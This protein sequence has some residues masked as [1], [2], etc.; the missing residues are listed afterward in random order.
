L[1]SAGALTGS[2]ASSGNFSIPVRVSDNLGLST[3]RNLSLAVSAALTIQTPSPLASA[4][5]GAPYSQRLLA[6]GGAPPI[7]WSLSAGSLPPGLSLAAGGLISGTPQVAADYSFTVQAADTSGA[8]A[9]RQYS[10]GVAVGIVIATPPLLRGGTI[11]TPYSET[12]EASGGR[13]PYTWS[14]VEGGLP[15]GVRLDPVSGTL[16]GTPAATGSFGFTAAVSDATA[17]RASK[18]FTLTIA[19]PLTISSAPAL[20][21]ATAGAAYAVPLRASGGRAPYTWSITA[22]TLPQ[23]LELSPDGGLLSGTPAA[24]GTYRFTVR[25]EDSASAS[26]N[27][28]FGLTV[29]GALDITTAPA[30]SGA[31]GVPYRQTLSASGGA[32]PYTWTVS[33]GSLPSGVSLSAAGE[34]AGTPSA[35]GQYR[36]TVRVSDSRSAQSSKDFVLEV[37]FGL[38]ITTGPLPPAVAGESYSATFAAS[39]GSEPYAWS[40]E[41]GALPE[42]IALNASTGELSGA[43]AAAGTFNF[44]MKVVDAEGRSHTRTYTIVAELPGAPSVRLTGIP[45]VAASAGQTSFELQMDAPFPVEISGVLTLDFEPDAAHNIDDPAVQFTT[46]GRSVLFRF[47]AGSP[48]AI[49]PDP[50]IAIQTGTV[51]GAIRLRASLSAAGRNLA[52]SGAELQTIVIERA[53]PVIRSVRLRPE[54]QTLMVEISGHSTPRD[55]KSV[56]LR[57]EPA[58]GASIEGSEFTLPLEELAANWYRS[59]ASARFG[60]MF[61]IRLPFNVQGTADAVGAATAVLTSE[62][63]DSPPVRS[64]Q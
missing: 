12:L 32:P 51:S 17:S 42:G 15:D 49:F 36:F 64:T 35:G 43:P 40:L 24:A 16:A 5:L 38:T 31:L 41:S 6:A 9:S 45:P 37:G 22:G 3:T 4:S 23:G 25:V 62:L 55:L 48:K 1:N 30:L 13:Q 10:I 58:P 8:T 20:P 54:G 33:A 63:G 27:I 52:G 56:R 59:A 19:A 39:G 60:S 26:A 46:G 29:A 2:P 21:D 28:E 7:L 18:Q 11:R 44:T 47:P 14:I 61:T 34:L 53:A 50:Q 57:F